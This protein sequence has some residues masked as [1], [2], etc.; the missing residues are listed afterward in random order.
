MRKLFALLALLAALPAFAAPG[1]VAATSHGTGTGNFTPSIDMTGVQGLLVGCVYDAATSE[2]SSVTIGAV[3]LSQ[4][5]NSPY[6]NQVSS[7]YWWFSGDTTAVTGSQTLTITVSGATNKVCFSYRLSGTN[8]LQQQAIVQANSGFGNS[9]DVGTLALMGETSFAA[10][11]FKHGDT[12]VGN[13]APNTGWTSTVEVDFGP[14]TGGAYSYDTIAAT[15]ID[16]VGVL[17]SIGDETYNI[18]AVAI[19]EAAGGGGGTVVNPITG[20]GGAAAQPIIIH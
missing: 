12:N 13:V 17:Y 19:S 15:D 18:Y 9:S 7:V 20:R 11:A 16:P 5:A 8:S 1:L 4:L 14:N 3:S 6:Q 10:I 2:I